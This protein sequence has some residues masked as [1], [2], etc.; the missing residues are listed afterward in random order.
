MGQ[1]VGESAQIALAITHDEV[2]SVNGSK[3]G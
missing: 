2:L 1:K 3:A